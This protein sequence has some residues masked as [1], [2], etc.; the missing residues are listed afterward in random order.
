MQDNFA[1]QLTP[2][3]VTNLLLGCREDYILRSIA[4]LLLYLICD[5]LAFAVGIQSVLMQATFNVHVMHPSHI[6]HVEA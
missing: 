4:L 6:N 2:L 1:L 3:F 5:I